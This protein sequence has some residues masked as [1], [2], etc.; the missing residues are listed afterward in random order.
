MTVG[1]VGVIA[2][3]DN[4]SVHDVEEL[5]VEAERAGANWLGLA[6]AF[7]WRDVWMLL[8][9]AARVTTTIRIGPVVTNP[10][11]RHRFHTYAALATL[12]E[13]AGPRV[14][15]GLAAGGSEVSGAARVSRHD[16]GRR[17]EELVAGMHGV[18]GGEP[19]DAQSGRRLEV[20]LGPVPV[21]V[22]GRGTG[23]LRAAGRCSDDAL[24]WAIP[25]SDL[26][27]T[28]GVITGAAAEVGRPSPR[29]VW[30]PLLVRTDEEY[31]RART[32]AAY[33]ILNATAELRTRWGVVPSLVDEIRLRLV[34]GGAA[35]A[36]HLVP[37][38][39]FADVALI[40]PTLTDVVQRAHTIGATA[41]AVP[42]YRIEEIAAQVAFAM[43]VVDV[44]SERRRG[45]PR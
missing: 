33:G 9:A 45:R 5:A 30:A 37:D 1:A 32:I 14:F 39:V 29:L 22:A 44:I 16:A 27:R 13:M 4:P 10:Y 7:W 40:D 8:S 18:I 42:A 38:A 11:M 35:A 12:Q 19:L 3:V 36:A 23:M 41:L 2:H 20:R 43:S 6:D 24:L 26:E 21:M 25:R 17:V 34:A 31:E 15:L 28:V